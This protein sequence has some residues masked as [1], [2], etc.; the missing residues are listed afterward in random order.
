M[1]I[2]FEKAT[3]QH[4]DTIFQWLLEPHMVEF[5]DNSQEHKDDIINFMDGRK[6]PSNYFCGTFLYWVCYIDDTPFAFLLSDIIRPDQDDLSALQR[7]HMSKSGTTVGIDFGIGNPE[8]LG[9]G[10]AAPTLRT[11]MEFYSAHVDPKTDTFFIDPDHKN[12]RAIHV[13]EKAGF[14]LAGNFIMQNSTFFK[15]NQ[16]LLMVKKMPLT[17]N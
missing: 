6:V 14:E 16:S 13:Y 1:K 8:F 3:H 7:A 4:K 12:L 2:H 17:R 5:W 15:G 11:F 9:K 10:L